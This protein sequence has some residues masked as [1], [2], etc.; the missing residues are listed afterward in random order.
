MI[1][2]VAEETGADADD[3]R[4][5]DE[6]LG[7]AFGLTADDPAA[8]SAA[9]AG[10]RPRPDRVRGGDRQR[11]PRYGDLA[12]PRGR[13]PATERREEHRLRPSPQCA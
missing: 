1:P 7:W 10:R 12:Q 4:A 3:A 5:W 13:R 2:C 6:R 11:T 8:R 9:R